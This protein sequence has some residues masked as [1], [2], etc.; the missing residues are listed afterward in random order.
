M[1]LLK[2]ELDIANDADPIVVLA[3]VMAIRNVLFRA[4]IA[5]AAA[6][7]AGVSAGRN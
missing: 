6:S 4:S 3:I 1:A 5:G 7:T 2:S